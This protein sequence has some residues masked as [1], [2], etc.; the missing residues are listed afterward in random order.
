ML[1]ARNLPA[2]HAYFVE[3]GAASVR[4][5]AD[6]RSS[7]EVATLGLKDFVGLPIVLATGRSP[8]RCEVQVPGDALRVSAED[9]TSSWRRSQR[10]NEFCCLLC[11]RG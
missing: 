5:R 11:R 8:H 10:Y 9:I 7:I 6:D 3:S 2:T 1:L 4:S